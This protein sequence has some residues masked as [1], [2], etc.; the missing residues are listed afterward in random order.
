MD[1]VY[2]IGLGGIAPG[3]RWRRMWHAHEVVGADSHVPVMAEKVQLGQEGSLW[4]V[5]RMVV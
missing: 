2:L 1:R 5:G 3:P 4:W